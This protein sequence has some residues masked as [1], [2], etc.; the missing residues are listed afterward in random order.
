MDV[1]W[2]WK[3]SW[4]LQNFGF[5][6]GDRSIEIWF[7]FRDEES[8][9]IKVLFRNGI[10]FHTLHPRVIMS[11]KDEWER[12]VQPLYVLR[13]QIRWMTVMKCVN[14]GEFVSAWIMFNK[15]EVGSSGCLR[16]W[17]SNSGLCISERARERVSNTR[18]GDAVVPCNNIVEQHRVCAC[19]SEPQ[20]I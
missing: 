19:T 6:C 17:K 7:L 13:Y 18:C 2:E 14:V 20:G 11:D 16:C 15:K 8:G 9:D 3:K 4:C 12:V 1:V 5:L 10:Q